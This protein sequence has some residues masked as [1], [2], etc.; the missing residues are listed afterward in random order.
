MEMSGII[1]QLRTVSPQLED[2]FLTLAGKNLSDDLE[3]ISD[4]W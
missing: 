2:V 1:T 3:P 4:D